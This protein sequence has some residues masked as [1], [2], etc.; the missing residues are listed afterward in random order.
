MV[1]Q[2]GEL[3]HGAMKPGHNDVESVSDGDGDAVVALPASV[4]S[5]K[6]PLQLGDTLTGVASSTGCALMLWAGDCPCGSCAIHDH[7]RPRGLVFSN[8]M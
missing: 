1:P 5:I 8:F 7:H 3:P 2:E 4:A 6:L